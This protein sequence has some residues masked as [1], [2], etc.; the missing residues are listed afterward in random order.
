M[1]EIPVNNGEI[2]VEVFW[3]W[4]KIIELDYEYGWITVGG[5]RDDR[6]NPIKADRKFWDKA[7][8]ISK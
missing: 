2:T 6:L 5:V 1:W 4:L 3:T 8:N 7:Q